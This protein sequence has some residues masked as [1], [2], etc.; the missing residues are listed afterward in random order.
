MTKI[1]S[2]SARISSRS[3]LISSTAAPLSAAWSRNVCTCSTAETSRPARRRA[4][5]E[6]ARAR[7]ELTRDHDLLQVAARQVVRLL[8]GAGRLDLEGL[9]RL[10]GPGAHRPEP[11]ERP[12]GVGTKRLEREVHGDRK[13]R[14]YT[15]AESVLGHVGDPG[16]ERRPRVTRAHQASLDADRAG[17]VRPQT[18]DRL[19][20]L[21][22]AVAGDAGDGRDLARTNGERDAADRGCTAPV[23]V[24][25]QTVDLEHRGAALR[26]PPLPGDRLDLASDHQRGERMWSRVG[27]LDG[28][29]RLARTQHGDAV[30]D[31]LHLVELVRDEDDRPAF[32]RDLAERDEQRIGLL[33]REHCRR[34]V[35]NQHACLLIERLQDLDPLLLADR[36]LP[37]ARTRIDVE[38]VALAELAHLGIDD[39]R[40][41]PEATAG[42]AA[43]TEHEVLGDREPGDQPELLVHHPDARVDRLARR[44][45]VDLPAVEGDGALVGAVQ[46]G[47]DV[48]QRASSR[49][50]SR[51]A[52]RAPR[53]APPRSRPRRLRRCRGTAS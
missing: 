16:L 37:D 13:T 49:R 19:G 45:E 25:P 14:S 11:Q 23:A 21:A 31:R 22:L 40:N 5:D 47:E 10:H 6:H 53:L 38:A 34:L 12:E 46:A 44:R 20:Q 18:G 3:S 29:D 41:D 2:W 1:R 15:G 17:R 7:A 27:R 42:A 35:E 24:D 33:R 36:E 52:A 50:R 8:V 39:A 9:D 43:I 30:R 32:G 4:R 26:G 48:R 28:R 51:P